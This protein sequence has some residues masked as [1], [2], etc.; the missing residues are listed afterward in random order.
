MCP[1]CYIG[2]RHYEEAIAS[3]ADRG[4]IEVIW[5]S[6]QLDPTLP[7]HS[8]LSVYEYLVER[9]GMGVEQSKA[10]HD[11]VVAMAAKAGLNYNFDKAVVANSFNAH[12]MIQMAKT[13]GLGDEAE[14]VLFKAYFIEGQN[15]GDKEV[16]S[17]LGQQIGLTE[18]DV[19]ESL[20]NDD[21]AYKVKQDIQEGQ[22]I[23]VQGV[24]FFV[25]NR[26]YAVSGAQPVE[27]FRQT[28]EKSYAEWKA[29]GV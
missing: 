3:F 5:K 11:N 22:S 4:D 15:F 10:M 24:P 9:K 13:K 6:F 27:A 1:F 29:A 7:E 18:A 16:L 12:R 23:G 14:E 17:E 8:E 20:T 2:K 25:F 28:I 26:K 21:Y 19:K